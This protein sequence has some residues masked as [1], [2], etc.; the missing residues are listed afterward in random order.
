MKRV[1]ITLFLS[2]ALLLGGCW[3]IGNMN[4]FQGGGSDA[5]MDED[6]RETKYYKNGV[7]KTD[8]HIYSVFHSDDWIFGISGNRMIESSDLIHWVKMGKR[9]FATDDF[10]VADSSGLDIV[11]IGE[12]YLMPYVAPEGGICVAESSRLRGPYSESRALMPP[13]DMKEFCCNPSFF[14]AK[15]LRWL[16]WDTPHGI[17]M[18]KFNWDGDSPAVSEPIIIA[19][20]GFSA[21]R[22]VEKGGM[23]YLWTTRRGNQGGLVVGRSKDIEG[24]YYTSEGIPM[25]AAEGVTPTIL[26]NS[27]FTD[28]SHGSGIITDANNEDWILYHACANL[29][30]DRQPV[31]MLDKIMWDNGWPV[32][33]KYHASVVAQRSPRF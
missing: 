7:F 17:Y 3:H 13:A 9:T 19:A 16:L 8:G 27:E 10:P 32:M 11:R 6:V 15:G 31:L 24:P 14:T 28:I 29:N 18:G 12:K 1:I 5:L 26:P 30:G 22:L 4:S 33:G 20:S 23:Y 25:K 2:G 21:P